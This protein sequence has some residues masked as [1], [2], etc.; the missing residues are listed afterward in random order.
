MA[1]QNMSV[2]RV[3]SYGK[4]GISIR[5]R[6]N[7]RKNEA[8]AN[9]SVRLEMSHLNVHFK[10]PETTYA[11]TLDQ[12]I[13]NQKVSLRGLRDNAKVWNEMVFDINSEYFEEHGDYE[14]AEKRN[15][16]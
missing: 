3:A 4:G 2:V 10:R 7:E 14:F 11:Q 15:G 6:H 9:E 1:K 5:E 12:M 8:Y 13:E 16:Q